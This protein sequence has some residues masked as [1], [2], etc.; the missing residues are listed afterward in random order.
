[1]RVTNLNA[2]HRQFITAIDLFFR[3]SDPVSIH[4]L[5]SNSREI[6]EKLL[7]KAGKE[8]VFDL[9][10]DS[11]PNH[12][13]QELWNALNY[14]RNFFKHPPTDGQE[15]CEISFEMNRSLLFYASLDCGQLCGPNHPIKIQ[16]YAV[17]FLATDRTDENSPPSPSIERTAFLDR[18]FPGLR[19]ASEEEQL[20]RWSDILAV[21]DQLTELD[22]INV[23]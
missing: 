20:L 5:A 2:A 6:Y 8:R 4:S 23:S 15:E 7:Q 17:W 16:A 22:V 3:R 10:R 13:E 21:A 1:M 18:Q 19:Q 12:T 11:H 14:S 9:I